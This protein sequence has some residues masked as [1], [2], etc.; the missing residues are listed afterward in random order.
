MSLEFTPDRK[1]RRA[2]RTLTVFIYVLL[3]VLVLGTAGLAVGYARAESRA[4][5]F[6]AAVACTATGRANCAQ[7]VQEQP[8]GLVDAGVKSGKSSLYWLEVTGVFVPDQTVDLSCSNASSFFMTAQGNGSLT[9]EVW[10][11]QVINLTYNGAETC[12]VDS[13]PTSQA[14]LWLIFLGIIGSITLG[15][16]ALLIGRRFTASSGTRILTGAAAA[17]IFL[18]ALIFPVLA[19]VLGSRSLWLYLPAYAIG[20]VLESPI[21]IKTARRRNDPKPRFKTSRTRQY[22]PIGTSNTMAA[23]RT[24]H[25]GRITLYVMIG[26]CLLGTAILLVF[27]VP[28][29]SNAFAYENAAT[30]RGA[31]TNGCVAN[32]TA[33]VVDSG[34]YRVDSGDANWIEING[35]GISDLQFTLSGDNAYGLDDLDSGTKLTALVWQGRVVE[36]EY[37][38]STS[39]GPSTPAKSAADLLAGVYAFAGAALLFVFLRLAVVRTE[40]RGLTHFAGILAPTALLGGAF[41]SIPLVVE[42]KPVWWA[43]PL[44]FGISAIIVTPIYLIVLAGSR[45]KARRRGSSGRYGYHPTP[46]RKS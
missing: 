3:A 36:L 6:T 13:D 31:A 38:G 26:L 28:A 41:A 44:T 12:Q 24:R 15:W 25:R 45:R 23:A 8:V 42:A 20:M 19:G 46:S 14:T 21:V 30:C 4:D 11:G 37:Q 29:Q 2:S 27:Y 32:V 5:A 1:L 9:A 40:R 33:T 39:P 18:N 17:P 35:P 7:R 22:A 34:S 10:N 43:F 16:L